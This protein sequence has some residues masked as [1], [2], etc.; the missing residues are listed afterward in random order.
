M[1]IRMKH[2]KKRRIFDLILLASLPVWLYSCSNS[3]IFHPPHR[4]YQP[5]DNLVTIDVENDEKIAAFYLPADDDAFVILHSHG[6]AEDIGH[7][8]DYVRCFKMEGFGVLA[9]DYRGYGLSDGRPSEQ[10]T[11]KDIEAA[12]RHLVDEQKI[13]PQRIIVH[14]RSVGSGPSVWLAANHPVGGL[15]LISPF[16]SAYRTRT[17]WPIL[18]FDKYNNMSRIKNIDCPLLVMHGRKD[19]VIG[20]RH[21][22]KLYEAA[23]EPKMCYWVDNAGHNDFLDVAWDDYWKTLHDF[24]KLVK[25][26]QKQAGEGNAE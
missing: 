2:S 21:G 25:Q 19:R 12:Y 16:L 13:D 22:E 7:L 23:N 10:N 6:N 8:W 18:P 4:S 11:Y 20:F 17:Y 24:E 26:S 9:Y 3:L 1:N 5:T 15:V 14:G